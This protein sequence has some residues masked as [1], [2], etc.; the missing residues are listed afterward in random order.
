[1]IGVPQRRPGNKRSVQA[2][3]CGPCY[4]F[5]SQTVTIKEC[6]QPSYRITMQREE[7]AKQ[8]CKPQSCR[9]SLGEMCTATAVSV[10]SV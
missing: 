5:S 2:N 8:K 9:L 1:M 6:Q 10:W 4:M 7:G 3:C